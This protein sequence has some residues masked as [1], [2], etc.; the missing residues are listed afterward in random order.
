MNDNSIDSASNSQPLSGLIIF[1]LLNIIL[2]VTIS[3]FSHEAIVSVRG[4]RFDFFPRWVGAQA[5]WRGESP[6]SPQVTSEI[7]RGMFGAELPPDLDQQNFAYPAYTAIL[8][9]P[10]LAV[11][12]HVAI[13]LWMA[14]QF[15]C[16][17]WSVIIWIGIVGWRPRPVTLCLLL[18]LFAFLF[19]Y[20]VNVYVLAQFTGVTLLL[21]S[22]STWFLIKGHD[23]VAGITLALATFSP[24]M[25]LPYSLGIIL[26]HAIVRRWRIL[27][28]FIATLFTL[29]VVSVVQVGW[30]ISDFVRVIR[31]YSEYAR[32]L[33]AMSIFDAGAV[34]L[35]AIASV[36]IF[37]I[38]S[39]L[40]FRSRQNSASQVDM[41]IAGNICLLLLIPQTGNYYLTLLIPPMIVIIY[42]ARQVSYRNLI[43]LAVILNV[44]SAWF[45]F[46]FTGEASILEAFM[47][48]FQTLVIWCAVNIPHWYENVRFTD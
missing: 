24:T 45:Y 32:P 15:L 6:Y 31:A 42:R 23:S 39:Y 17:C 7:Q 1:L 34:R 5:Y 40:R 12:S 21:F 26:S 29:I 38:W 25:A 47:L 48:P 33:W 37:A 2:L 19:R 43:W 35:I 30:W 4:N 28:T 13:S 22:V 3:A 46:R 10:L 20:S 9:T 41:I 18:L 16:I 11:P 36:T 8:V 27:L 44:L 14:F